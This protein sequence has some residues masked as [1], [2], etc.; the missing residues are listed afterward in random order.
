VSPKSKFALLSE[1]EKFLLFNFT[2]KLKAKSVVLEV[3]TFLGGSAVIMASANPKITIHTVDNYYDGHDRNKPKVADMLRE[4]LGDAPR[5]LESVQTLVGNYKNIVLHKG[6]S[7]IDFQDWNSPIDVYFEDGWHSNP[8]FTQ[9]IEFWTKFLK[10]DGYL[11]LHDYR[12]F[13]PD[14]HPSKMFDVIKW[15]DQVSSDYQVVDQVDSLIIF[16]KLI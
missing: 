6:K 9:N 12:P 8:I 15:V 7:P 14:D 11:I 3:G 2:T 16:K 10:K 1:K 4:A 13:L 5:S